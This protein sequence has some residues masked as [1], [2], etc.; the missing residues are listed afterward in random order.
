MRSI[1]DTLGV[2]T[3]INAK[4]PSTRVGGGI[5]ET[6]VADIQRHVALRI[7]AKSRRGY[8]YRRCAQVYC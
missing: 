3:I 2:P 7:D 8:R 4:G 6:E 1:Y 5:M